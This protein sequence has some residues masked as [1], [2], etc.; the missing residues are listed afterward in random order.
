M[1]ENRKGDKGEAGMER[2]EKGGGSVGWK[3]GRKKGRKEGRKIL[4]SF[5]NKE[6]VPVL[7]KCTVT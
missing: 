2:K 4:Y 6:N 1:L 7:Y 5:T 3:G